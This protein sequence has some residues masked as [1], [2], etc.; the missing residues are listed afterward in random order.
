MEDLKCRRCGHLW[1]STVRKPVQCPKCKSP[2]WAREFA[3]R[4]DMELMIESLRARVK[5]LEK[6]LADHGIQNQ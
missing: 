6:T 1:N 5:F 4:K 2:N 3:N